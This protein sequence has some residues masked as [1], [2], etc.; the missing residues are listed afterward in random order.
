MSLSVSGKGRAEVS[1]AV[2]VSIPLLMTTTAKSSLDKCES[3]L[4]YGC[5]VAGPSTA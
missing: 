1:H 2:A 5:T 4:S 3:D